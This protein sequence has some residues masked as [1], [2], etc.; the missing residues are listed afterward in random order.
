MFVSEIS[1]S[2]CGAFAAWVV[3]RSAR[4]RRS[5][6]ETPVVAIATAVSV[7]EPVR[8]ASERHGPVVPL[9]APIEIVPVTPPAAGRAAVCACVLCAMQLFAEAAGSDAVAC[10][11]FGVACPPQPATAAPSVNP[12][13]AKKERRIARLPIRQR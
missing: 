9:P 6:A 8:S 11:K 5:D 12:A 13:N 7:A 2:G 3:R 10:E 1:A 4:A